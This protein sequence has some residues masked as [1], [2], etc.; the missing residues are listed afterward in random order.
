[1]LFQEGAVVST[2]NNFKIKWTPPGCTTQTE[3]NV[4]ITI[5]SI[6]PPEY[7]IQN[8]RN[9]KLSDFNSDGDHI[10]EIYNINLLPSRIYDGVTF[11]KIK[12][13]TDIE[14]AVYKIERTE[15]GAARRGGNSLRHVSRKR[16]SNRRRGSNKKYSA[17]RGRRSR[18][19]RRSSR[20]T[21]KN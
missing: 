18:R 17:S 12:D 21:R 8:I 5:K 16:K 19:S 4:K 10:Y 7:H 15:G 6:S 20:R 2:S 11:K 1:M 14:P 3:D 9:E 13:A